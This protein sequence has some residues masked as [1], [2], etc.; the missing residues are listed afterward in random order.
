MI[1]RKFKSIYKIYRACSIFEF[2]EFLYHYFFKKKYYSKGYKQYPLEFSPLKI[3]NVVGFINSQVTKNDDLILVP[4][5][6]LG[7]IK[8]LGFNG[9]ITSTLELNLLG[10]LSIF[11]RL[12]WATERVDRSAELALF[13][14]RNN[15]KVVVMS[16]TGPAKVWMHDDKKEKILLSE[17]QN[18]IEEKIEKFG[19]GI[20]ADFGNL[21]Q[22]IDNTKNIEGDFLEI[23]CFM[24]SSTCVIAKYMNELKIEK[25]LFVY[26]YFD[27]FNYDEAKLS[28]DNSWANTHKTDGLENVKNRVLKRLNLK[29]DCLLIYKRNVIDKDAIKEV[30]KIAF[31]NIDVDIYEAVIASLFHVHSKISKN[32]II[33]VEDAGHTPRLLGAKVA[34]EEFLT[35]IGKEV[36]ITL[37][38]D[39]G[40]YILIKK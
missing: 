14:Y 8:K 26:D 9:I 25:K 16:N 5:I 12:I 32:G 27:G 4:N 15:K 18:Q 17:Y 36:Y 20:G 35:N 3:Y 40:Q 10:D 33:V 39:S 22:I 34:L 11:K 6:Y 38:M 24:G 13:F 31:A 28:T 37:Q 30:N 29:N 1:L 7:I 21:L 19:H 2:L 23:G